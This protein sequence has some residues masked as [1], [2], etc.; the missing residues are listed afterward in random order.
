M[1]FTPALL[2]LLAAYAT[3]FPI[4]LNLFGKRAGDLTLDTQNDLVNGAPCA[5]VT[6]IW[7][8]GTTAPGNVGASESVG[9]YFFRAVAAA[10]GTNNLAVQGVTYS[11]SILGFLQGGDG[12]G[13]TT[14]AN[15]VEQ[16]YRQ[17]PNTKVV[18]SGFSQGAQIVHN[19]ARQLSAVSTNKVAAVVLFG[20]PMFGAAVGTI[21]TSKIRVF[22]N[23]GDNICAGGILILTPH[24]TYREN[25][26]EAAQF[27][28]ARVGL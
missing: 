10:I 1:K 18:M 14:M 12:P 9:P 2:S 13:S 21:A 8:R 6:L 22:C 20:D 3:A 5:P 15:L 17:C 27:V 28:K 25:A 19:A 4:S 24:T 16:A 11:A 26:P 23:D 7:A